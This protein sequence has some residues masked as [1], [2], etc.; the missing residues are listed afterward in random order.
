MSSAAANRVAL[1]TLGD[2]S[3]RTGG[4]LY[5]ARMIA[6]CRRQRELPG[7]RTVEQIALPPG[8]GSEEVRRA[9]TGCRPGLLI[10]DSIAF[11]PVLPLLGWLRRQ[12]VKTLALMHM[13]PSALAE[14]PER[15]RR[16]ERAFLRGVD[17]AVA[18][19]SDLAQQLVAAGATLDQVQV[20]RPGRDGIPVLRRRAG[21]PGVNRFLT[22]ANWTESKGIHVAVAAF[23]QLR[24]SGRPARLDLVGDLGNP[25]YADS[26]RE[27]IGASDFA[28]DIRVRGSLPVD[29][30]ARRYADADVFLL[31]S[32]SE[33][34]GIVY[35]EALSHGLPVIA[36]RVGTG[37]HAGAAGV[38]NPRSARR[39]RRAPSGDGATGGRSGPSASPGPRGR[40]AG[41]PTP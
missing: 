31:P 29:Q 16:A 5:N 28:R 18:V 10:V 27:L 13:L 23:L 9:V 15:V 40:S 24:A 25:P 33:G 3:Q 12:G 2:P 35:A 32:R 19:S 14:E 34:F 20:V 11:E 8:D 38:W 39:P 4:Y 36:C 22:V 37:S 17:Q 6:A 21:P 30:L 7:S 41:A 1:L 26:V